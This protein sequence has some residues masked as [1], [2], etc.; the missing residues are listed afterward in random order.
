[1]FDACHGLKLL[2]NLLGDKGALLSSTCFSRAFD[3]LNFR[4]PVASGYKAPL[5]PATLQWQNAAKE[6]VGQGLMKLQ[7]VTGKPVVQDGRRMS[8]ISLAFTLKSVSQLAVTLFGSNNHNFCAPRYICTPN[9]DQD[10]LEMHFSCVRQWGGWNNNP[11]ASEFR[12][13]Y[14]RT[15]VHAAVGGSQNANVTP[16]QEGI[17][18]AR[19]QGNSNSTCR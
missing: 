2:R 4:S 15:L 9:L 12:H 1:M 3:L 19:N 8:V 10:P 17:M 16:Q 18:L 14:R 5:R 11:S 6:S 13:A 7:L